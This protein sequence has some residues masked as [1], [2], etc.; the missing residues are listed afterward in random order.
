MSLYWITLYFFIALAGLSAIG[1]LLSRNLMYAALLL[2]ICLLSVAA[3]YVIMFAEFVAVTQI[4]VY[5]GG[6]LVVIIF[7]IMLTAR[8]TNQP[9]R[10]GNT[11]V[12]SGVLISACFFGL[13]TKLISN[14]SLAPS[15]RMPDETPSNI[16]AIGISFLTDYVLVFEVSGLLLL[17]A[18]IGAAVIA[19]H[20]PD[21][22]K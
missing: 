2:I 9:L 17:I 20:K 15:P 14:F 10:V 21:S 18:L 7:G 11:N 13:M 5:A 22:V 4:L 16:S 8:F 6:V 1:V 3:L 12:F 19:S